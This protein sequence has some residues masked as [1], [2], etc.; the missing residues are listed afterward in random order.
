VIANFLDMPAGDFVEPTGRDVVYIGPSDRHKGLSVL[1]TAGHYLPPGLA[2]LVVVGAPGSQDGVE[3]TGRLTGEA[4]WQRFRAAALVVIPSI[5]PEPCPTVAL[6][7]LGYGRPIVASRTG[8]LTDLV[9]H[10][11]TGLL[12]R[13]GD[14]RGLAAAITELLN[15]RTRLSA[16][17][18]AAHDSAGAFDTVPV[19]ARIEAVYKEVLAEW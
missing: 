11:R 3:F 2:R 12:V 17:A 19:V 18:R 10:G 14:P 4:L 13:P 15:D 8:G 7:A 1:L 5:W 9:A 6:E 16:M